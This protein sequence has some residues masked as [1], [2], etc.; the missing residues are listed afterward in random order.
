MRKSSVATFVASIFFLILAI[1]FA[2]FIWKYYYKP[3]KTT[4]Q[5]IAKK[6]QEE[7]STRSFVW[8]FVNE[9]YDFGAG[10]SNSYSTEVRTL[11]KW[12]KDI[13]VRYE[14]Y[15]PP[16]KS[17]N[18]DVEANYLLSKSKYMI[19]FSIG[20]SDKD[21]QLITSYIEKGGRVFAFDSCIMKDASTISQD[22]A[23]YKENFGITFYAI[24][25]DKYNGYITL[26]VAD[27]LKKLGIPDT[28]QIPV[29]YMYS[30]NLRSEGAEPLI[31]GRDGITEYSILTRYEKGES[32]NYYSTRTFLDLYGKKDYVVDDKLLSTID[33]LNRAYTIELQKFLLE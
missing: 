1:T 2:I 14:V 18:P 27:E 19:L 32:K 31:Y 10:L 7:F 8:L 3:S 16:L 15:T 5:S 13:G 24:D 17:Y 20:C 26:F 6:L 11:K 4:A 12:L 28:I 21:K 29:D 30:V 25:K 23:F 22:V 33:T 9:R